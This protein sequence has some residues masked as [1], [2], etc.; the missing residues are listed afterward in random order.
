MPRRCLALALALFAAAL[1]PARA[2]RPFSVG[3]NYPWLQE[4][5]QHLYG[6]L[7]GELTAARR[8]AIEGHF[9]DMQ[10]AGITM[11]RLWLLADGWRWPESGAASGGSV[12]VLADARATRSA[13]P[14]SASGRFKPLPPAFVEDLR[15]FVRAAH[16]H[17]I[18]VQPALWDFYI[19]RTHR[20]YLT[21]PAVLPELIEVVI[22]P[23]VRALAGEPGIASWDVINEP[24]WII[25]DK[26]SDGEAPHGAEAREFDPGQPH[27][28]AVLSRF[29][30][31]HVAALHAAG[32]RATLGSASTKWVAIWKGHDLDEYQVHY[33]PR[34]VI[35]WMGNAQFR[36]LPS[37]KRLGLDRPCVLGEFP[38]NQK[39]TD[40]AD[41]LAII[42]D[43]GYAGAWAWCYFGDGFPENLAHPFS[44]RARREEFRAFTLGR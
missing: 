41:V 30:K 19:N 14:E 31:A 34:A 3:L 13:R 20:E 18:R 17:G 43:K 15:W 25:A 28:F 29:V 10:G 12:Q 23:L 1:I 40:L 27:A 42:R 37:V 24:E 11:L 36:L 5:G 21:D 26:A 8:A 32:A 38:P 39:R 44:Y 7:F 22:A 33:Y 16:A 4:S 6:G 35:G 9:A 2:Q